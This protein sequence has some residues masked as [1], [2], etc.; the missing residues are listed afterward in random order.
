MFLDVVIHY[1]VKEE[2]QVVKKA[3]YIAIGTRLDGKKEV[4]GMY[5]GGN[6]SAKY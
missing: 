2:E 6:E 1:Y 5:I 4:M 3:V